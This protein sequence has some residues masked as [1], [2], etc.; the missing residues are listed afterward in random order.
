MSFKLETDLAILRIKLMLAMEK[1]GVH[2]VVGN[3]LS[4]RYERVF[5]MSRSPK[6]DGEEGDVVVSDPTEGYRGAATTTT[7]TTKTGL[8]DPP[9]GG[10]GYRVREIAADGTGSSD[11]LESATNEYVMTRHFYHISTH[12]SAGGGASSSTNRFRASATE[13]AVRRALEARAL[14]QDRL[15]SNRRRL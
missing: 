9:P 4:T 11:D 10:D 14:H 3:V 1:S 7:T 2:L 5:V 8:E 13:I 15:D 12:T 6:F